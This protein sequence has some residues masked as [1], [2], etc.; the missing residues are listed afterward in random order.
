M[1]KI[2]IRRRGGHGHHRIGTDGS[3]GR[4]SDRHTIRAGVGNL[5]VKDDVGLSGGAFDVGSIPTPLKS[6]RLLAGCDHLEIDLGSNQ[7]ALALRLANES[8]VTED[9]LINPV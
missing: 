8:R 3:T 1:F 2:I 9:S 5:G 4:V 7:N 6:E